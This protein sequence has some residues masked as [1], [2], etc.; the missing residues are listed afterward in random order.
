MSDA[1]IRNFCAYPC[2]M[3]FQNQFSK[4]PITLS[5]PASTTASVETPKT[6]TTRSVSNAVPASGPKRYQNRTRTVA[7]DTGILIYICYYL[8]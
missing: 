4:L 7:N 1:T 3:A 8:F 6:I 5:S 2:V